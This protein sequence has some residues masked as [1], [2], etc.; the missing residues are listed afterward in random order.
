MTSYLEALA[1]TT[2][3]HPPTP[4]AIRYLCDAQIQ[5]KIQ[6]GYHQKLGKTQTE[7]TMDFS[8]AVKQVAEA[9]IAGGTLVLVEP[10]IP[11]EEQ[12]KLQGIEIDP[13]AVLPA[14]Q[15]D[16]LPYSAWV[17]YVSNV[18]SLSIQQMISELPPSLQPATIFEGINL[19]ILK[20]LLRQSKFTALPGGL[21]NHIYGI[22]VLEMYKGKPRITHMSVNDSDAL[23]GILTRYRKR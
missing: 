19:S 7:Y 4:D 13:S 23:V 1:T 11:A 6:A 14:H 12:L 15:P 17:K 8:N 9:G 18:N 22:P 16:C 2:Q 10:R 20:I 5:S 3:E 21:V